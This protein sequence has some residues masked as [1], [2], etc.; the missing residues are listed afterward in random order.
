MWFATPPLGGSPEPRTSAHVLRPCGTT[1]YISF[2]HWLRR[3]I[4]R[5]EGDNFNHLTRTHPNPLPQYNAQ[6]A[7]R[8]NHVILQVHNRSRRRSC[9]RQGRPSLHL[10]EQLRFRRQHVNVSILR[11]RNQFEQVMIKLLFSRTCVAFSDNWSGTPYNGPQPPTIGAQ[12]SWSTTIPNGWDG[13]FCDNRNCYGD[14]S[15][16]E[17][18]LDAGNCTSSQ[19]SIVPIFLRRLTRVLILSLF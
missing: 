19:Y 5:L 14:G 3:D 18:N 2:R 6:P 8:L 15:L 10:A 1:A 9:R 4:S 13:R 12:S 11:S 7:T 16:T 17:F